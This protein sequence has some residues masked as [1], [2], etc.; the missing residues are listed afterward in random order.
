[1]S[2]PCRVPQPG[3]AVRKFGARRLELLGDT[4]HQ[5]AF[6]GQVAETLG[7]DRGL[8]TA[9]ARTHRRLGGEGDGA[10]L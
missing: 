8:Q 1:M 6:A 10:D 2:S 9:H 3:D 5:V 7:T 4:A